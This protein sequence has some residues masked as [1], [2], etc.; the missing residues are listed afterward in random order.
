MEPLTRA[1]TCLGIH[2]DIDG[3]TLSI[4][5]AKL[6]KIYANCLAASKKTTLSRKAREASVYPQMC[7]FGQNLRQ[8]CQA[9]K[10]HLDSG[11]RKDIEWCISFLTR[12]NG[13]TCLRRESIPHF[14]LDASLTGLGGTWSNRAYVTPVLGVPGFQLRIA[15]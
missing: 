11:F 15:H 7:T 5:S 12:F 3:N 8:N 9:K 1:L 4:G 13:V 6:K 2:I 10:H 14:D